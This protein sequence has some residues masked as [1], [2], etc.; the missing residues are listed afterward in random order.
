MRPRKKNKKKKGERRKNSQNTHLFSAASTK[1][2]AAAVVHEFGEQV[3]PPR[4]ALPK[5]ILRY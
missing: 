3:R 4:E 1:W 2:E 5:R